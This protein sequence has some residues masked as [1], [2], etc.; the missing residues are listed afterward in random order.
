[1]RRTATKVAPL[2]T[3]E[4]EKMGRMDCE[5]ASRNMA[6]LGPGPPASRRESSELRRPIWTAPRTDTPIDPPKFRV[7][8][9]RPEA[10]PIS[11]F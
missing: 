1:M 9:A 10:M 8:V 2:T 3:S 7:K 11:L 5:N 6:A 4:I